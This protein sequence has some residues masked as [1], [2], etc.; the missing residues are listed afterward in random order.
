MNN[1]MRRLEPFAPTILRVVA[2][3]T[4]ALHGWG[5]LGNPAGFAGFVGSLGFPAP[6]LFAWLVILLELVGGILLIVGFGTRWL[7]LLFAIEMLVTTILVKS[8]VGFIAPQGQPGVGFE[9][10][11]MLLAASLALAI[12][13]SGQL[14]VEWNLLRK[15]AVQWQQARQGT[16]AP[17]D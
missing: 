8:R 16:S 2:G 9:L 5:K 12:L 7:G 3:I 14:S 11:L 15:E 13:G 17:T 6:T 1:S 10:D 4:F